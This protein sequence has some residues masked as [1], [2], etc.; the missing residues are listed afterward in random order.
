MEDFLPKDEAP[1][2]G[3][4]KRKSKAFELWQ[5]WFQ[6]LNESAWKEPEKAD[7][8]DEDEEDDDEIE[9]AGKPRKKF[10]PRWKSFFKNLVTK[11]V[12][13][14]KAV[15]GEEPEAEL[16]TAIE[17][18]AK[19]PEV[20]TND[21]YLGELIVDHGQGVEPELP[22]VERFGELAPA[23][24]D[25]SME[26]P[27]EIEAIAEAEPVEAEKLKVSDQ[28]DD[29]LAIM[30][31]EVAEP[32]LAETR[33]PP[34][35]PPP[36]DSYGRPAYTNIEPSGT[37][38]ELDSRP[39]PRF[40]R[41]AQSLKPNEAEA[42][43]TARD[44]LARGLATWELLGRRRDKKHNRQNF[45]RLTK[46][47]L[48][49]SNQMTNMENELKSV[50][51]RLE[52]FKK[53]RPAESSLPPV[54]R[55]SENPVYE[56][57]LETIRPPETAKPPEAA[58][59]P[60]V[61]GASEAILPQPEEESK[62]TPETVLQQVKEAADHNIPFEG[63]LERSHEIKEPGYQPSSQ[64]DSTPND[65]TPAFMKRIDPIQS[66][67]PPPLIPAVDQSYQKANRPDNPITKSIKDKQLVVGGLW[68]ALMLIIF[69]ILLRYV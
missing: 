33:K 2:E 66:Y 69:F 21:N 50:K 6:S 24:Q 7:D 52:Q 40:D 49:Q 60:A 68:A 46:E 32:A 22:A 41:Q 28:V 35:T 57:P 63:Y 61:A 11:E 42:P 8:D 58:K 45:K 23:P 18:T 37:A 29:I 55:L 47:Q 62:A 67:T 65:S 54:N 39:L 5:R 19:T 3:V 48:T 17:A 31:P 44:P 27:D 38:R 30:P 53:N 26:T 16:S 9:T 4:K 43:E 20:I 56:K 36:I 59:P 64:K 10:R 13:P 12:P 1:V 34:A 51:E 15:T 14:K 25:K